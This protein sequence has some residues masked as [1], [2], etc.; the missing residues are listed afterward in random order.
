MFLILY[1]D[2]ILLATNILIMLH[3]IKE[4]LSKN[5]EMKYLG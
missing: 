4:Y 2:D 3:E 5:F 1:I